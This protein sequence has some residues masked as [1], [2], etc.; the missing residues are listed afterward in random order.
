MRKITKSKKKSN[1]QK[2]V[3]SYTMYVRMYELLTACAVQC[4]CSLTT[5]IPAQNFLYNE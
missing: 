4:R 2:C 1:T 5:P 3:E